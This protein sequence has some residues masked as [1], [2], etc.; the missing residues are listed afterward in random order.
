MG[1][2]VQWGRVEGSRE[3]GGESQHWECVQHHSC[4]HLNTVK[5]VNFMLRVFP[6]N[7]NWQE[8]QG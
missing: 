3:D 2:D 8:E 6:R 7:E 1:T 4:A 5:V